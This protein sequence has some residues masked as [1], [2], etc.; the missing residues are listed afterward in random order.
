MIPPILLSVNMNI[1][2]VLF[3][4]SGYFDTFFSEFS[5]Y[6]VLYNMNHKN[7]KYPRAHLCVFLLFM[8]FA[9]FFFYNFFKKKENKKTKICPA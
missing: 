9:I 4:K 7:R 6:I 1:L 8:E 3:Q 5:E 2:Y